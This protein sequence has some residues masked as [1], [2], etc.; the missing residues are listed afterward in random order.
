[1]ENHMC[2]YPK[3]AQKAKLF[4]K[5]TSPH[6][7]ICKAHIIKHSK[8]SE[9][10]HDIQPL[11]AE[12]NSQTKQAIIKILVEK[13]LKINEIKLESLRIFFQLILNLRKTLND[14][15]QIL[16]DEFIYTDNQLCS[17]ISANKISKLETDNL[18][19]HLTLDLNEAIQ[20][21]EFLNCDHDIKLNKILTANTFA[22][23]IIEELNAFTASSERSSKT[24]LNRNKESKSWSDKSTEELEKWEEFIKSWDEDCKSNPSSAYYYFKRG[25]IYHILCRNKDALEKFNFALKLK[26]DYKDAQYY[27]AIV[28][29]NLNKKEEAI[30]CF[31]ELSRLAPQYSIVHLSNGLILEGLNRGEDSIS[32]YN[33]FIE[34]NPDNIF[35]YYYKAEALKRLKRFEEAIDCC[36]RVVRINP[37]FSSAYVEKGFSLEELNRKEDALKC[38]KECI[39]I[40]PNQYHAFNNIG[41]L[42]DSHNHGWKAL[43]YYNNAIKINPEFPVAFYNKGVCLRSLGKAQ[44]ALECFREA[45]RLDKDEKEAREMSNEI[46]GEIKR[47]T[48]QI[49]YELS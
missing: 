12:A 1:M 8:S 16:D 30:S 40:D 6:T 47:K 9:L 20:S 17:V 26:P 29:N 15:L 48:S 7:L 49:N 35:G 13:K 32:S 33:K 4:C 38:Y 2:F 44:E 36:N 45:M 19:K 11:L 28:L 24:R 25:I 41:I 14:N 37:L 46:L 5:C 42:Y 27:K 22:G 23:E 31:T 3:C 39:K 34:L 10:S 18:L 43:E 21:L